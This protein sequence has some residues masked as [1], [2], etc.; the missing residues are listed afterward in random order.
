MTR[1]RIQVSRVPVSRRSSIFR[2]TTPTSVPSTCS[3][4]AGDRSRRRSPTTPCCRPDDRILVAVSGG[5]DSLAVWDILLELGYEADGLYLGLGIGEYSDESGEYAQRVRRRTRTHA[6]HDRS[7]RRVRIRRADRRQGDPACAVLGVR[8]V[9]AAPVRRG[10]AR[11]R[12]RRGRDRPQPRRRG[13]GA[14]RQRACDGTS[15]TSPGSFPCCRPATASPRRSSRWCGSPSARWRRGASC[16][17]STIRSRSAR[18]RSGNKHLAYKDALNAIERE[19]PGSKA[20]V[21]PQLRRADGAAP[22][23][24]RPQAA[25]GDLQTC[26]VCAVADDRRDRARSAG[27]GTRG[28]CIE[29]VPVEV[30]LGKKHRKAYGRRATPEVRREAARARRSGDVARRQEAALPDHPRRRRRVPQPRRV[31][32][33][34]RHRRTGGRASWCAR[35]RAP[36]TRCC[37]RRSRTT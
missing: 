30:V 17:A 24:T 23:R 7:A 22:G 15:S 29:P 10:R 16:A 9:E 4:C 20:A 14:V 37:G 26:A 33:A 31:R 5:K 21:L 3:N 27:C 12:L 32:A 1:Q 13:G 34:R 18:W 6:A 28:R 19:S 2:A 35:P 36:S 25:A 11:R 8:A